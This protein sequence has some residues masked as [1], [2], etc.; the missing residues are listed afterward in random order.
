[1][2]RIL[3][4]KAKHKGKNMTIRTISDLLNDLQRDIKKEDPK[5]TVRITREGE[6]DVLECYPTLDFNGESLM[7]VVE[8]RQ[9][10]IYM[11]NNCVPIPETQDLIAF[12]G[13]L[14]GGIE[15][16]VVWSVA[17]KIGMPTVS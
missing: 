5:A 7:V 4:I 12:T 8:P 10:S 17:S 1:M 16:Q 9:I 14:N 15:R 3:F 11:E 2:Y 6:N 13:R